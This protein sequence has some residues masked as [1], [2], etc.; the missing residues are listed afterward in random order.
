MSVESLPYTFVAM[1]GWGGTALIAN[2]VQSR[3]Y[4]DL[5]N[6]GVSKEK[7]LAS[8]GLASVI[9]TVDA[10]LEAKLLKVTYLRLGR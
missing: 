6:Q 2:S 3:E 4:Y 1:A 10:V 7:S 5:R 8:S 9:E